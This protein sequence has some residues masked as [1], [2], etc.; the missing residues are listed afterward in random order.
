MPLVRISLREG[1]PIEIRHA[2][3]DRVHRTLVKTMGVPEADRFHLVTE[4]DA[5]GMTYDPDYLGTTR[6]TMSSS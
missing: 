6:R 3:A 5:E 4:H 1:K 2:I